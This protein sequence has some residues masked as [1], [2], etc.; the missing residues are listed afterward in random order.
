MKECKVRLSERTVRSRTVV[1]Q[2]PSVCRLPECP[3]CTPGDAQDSY[4]Q[5]ISHQVAPSGKA[6]KSR[7]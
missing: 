5:I 3:S 6:E 7:T 2:M 1:N 4:Q